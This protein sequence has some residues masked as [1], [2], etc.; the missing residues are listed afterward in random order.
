MSVNPGN[1]VPALLRGGTSPNE[2]RAGPAV[3]RDS[4]R[5]LEKSKTCVLRHHFGGT[6]GPD[7]GERLVPYLE[8]GR[9][10]FQCRLP[11]R[12]LGVLGPCNGGSRAQAPF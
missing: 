5:R 8:P 9:R 1:L 12:G 3:G 11:G 7:G 4:G 10:R 6:V 2:P